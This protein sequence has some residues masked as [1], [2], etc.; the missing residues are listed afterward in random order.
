MGFPYERLHAINPKI[1]AVSMTGFGETGPDS[2]RMAMARSS[3][4]CPA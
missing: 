2:D 3:T 1:V 4:R